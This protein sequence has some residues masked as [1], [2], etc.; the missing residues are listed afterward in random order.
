MNLKTPLAPFALALLGVLISTGANAQS[1]RASV[2]TISVP[3]VGNLDNRIVTYAYTPHVVY[4]LKVT[5]GMHT[6]IQ[7]G[8]DEELIETPRF[9]DTVRWRVEGNEK[10]LYVK[11]LAPGIKTSMSL[12]TSR[13]TYQFELQATERDSERIQKVMF[14]YPDTEMQIQ[15]A[16]TQLR[17]AEHEVIQA[18]IQQVRSQN[19]T[20]EPI[21]PSELEF[22]KIHSDDPN[23]LRMH[24]YTDGIKTWVRMPPG[25][26]DLPAVF[27]VE[28]NERGKETLMP[29]NYTVA[30]RKNIRDRDV[31]IIDRVHPL[32]MLKI[33][34]FDVRI[35]NK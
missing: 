14:S 25:I 2:S 10:N 23:M 5:V 26:Q 15:Q 34:S 12:V 31:I 30:E 29:V 20:S 28:A 13:R 18:Q 9:G 27:M 17:A 8:P 3:I 33:G 11:A 1:S 16:R 19:L 6:H 21:D 22:L 24:A 35:S 7:L 32:W 4:Q